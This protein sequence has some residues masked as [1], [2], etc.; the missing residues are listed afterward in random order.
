MGVEQPIP[1][2]ELRA[3]RRLMFFEV[4]EA[5]AMIGRTDERTW[6]SWEAGENGL[7]VSVAIDFTVLLEWYRARLSRMRMFAQL[8]STGLIAHLWYESLDDWLSLDGREALHWRPEQAVT[9]AVL[10]EFT[11]RFKLVTFDL[12]AYANWLS[13]REDSQSE[14]DAW[15]TLVAKGYFE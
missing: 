2:L 12:P 4:H 3:V 9:A 7:P 14:R 1:P 11:D 13:G 15:T 10:G 5:A 8:N 6:A